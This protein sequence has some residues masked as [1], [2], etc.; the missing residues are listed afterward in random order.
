MTKTIIEI[1]RPQGYYG[2][3]QENGQVT[4]TLRR[5]GFNSHLWHTSL[6]AYDIKLLLGIAALTM[7]SWDDDDALEAAKRLEWLEKTKKEEDEPGQ[8]LN[9]G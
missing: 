5:E 8:T 2:E 1:D 6:P 7:T 9:G 4:I 3:K